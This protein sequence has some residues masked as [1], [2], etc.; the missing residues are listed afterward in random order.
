MAVFFIQ[1]LVPF[2]LFFYRFQK[3]SW[4]WYVG[5]PLLAVI[6]AG[7]Y[8]AEAA[9]MLLPAPWSYYIYYFI[10]YL[11]IVGLAFLL[12]RMPPFNVLFFCVFSFAVQNVAHH[13]CQMVVSVV[14]VASG[15]D[16]LGTPWGEFLSYF[17]AYAAVYALFF[18]GPARGGNFEKY[19]KLSRLPVL[20]LATGFI[21]VL[22]VLGIYVKHMSALLDGPIAVGYEIYSTMLGV[23]LVALMMGSF[24]NNRLV[25]ES[26]EMELRLAQEGHYYEMAQA[27]MEML[28]IKC[29]DLKHQIA[30]LR[31]LP[32]S[33]LRDE[34][35]EEMANE[36]LIY[37]SFAKTGNSALD[38]VL[39]EKSLV[40]QRKKITFSVMADGDGL[41]GLRYSD[42][43]SLFGNAID[44][45]VEC[46]EKYED[47]EK[48]IISLRV[49]VKNGLLHIHIENYCEDPPAAAGQLPQTTKADKANHG[50]GLKSM[51]YIVQKYDGNFS[52]GVQGKMFRV[53]ALIPLPEGENVA[54]EDK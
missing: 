8:F 3:R 31:S 22:I 6:L 53:N 18:L 52:A 33:K 25:E 13:L 47:E 44:N 49:F 42:I 50:F 2:L 46:V 45:A 24:R 28:N 37:E 20:L 39:T 11:L 32:D 9:V 15:Y 17:I 16:L 30:A 21:L 35:I 38:C 43:C 26:H 41:A 12:F 34:S 54:E 40:C 23:F 4:F 1:L 51:R 27:N 29:H 5:L 14:L 10:P 7:L 48:R 36:I 19:V